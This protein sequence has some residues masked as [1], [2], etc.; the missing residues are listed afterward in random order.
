MSFSKDVRHYRSTP[1]TLNQAFGPYARLDVAKREAHGWLWAI[2]CGI[3][4]GV[5]WWFVVALRVGG[6]T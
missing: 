5:F 2:G 1:R 4:I 6:A 3:G